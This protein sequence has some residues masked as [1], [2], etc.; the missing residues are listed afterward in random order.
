MANGDISGRGEAVRFVSTAQDQHPAW[1]KEISDDSYDVTVLST[2]P[3]RRRPLRLMLTADLGDH[4]L[5][6]QLR[7]VH[8]RDLSLT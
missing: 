3:D 6:L 5:L 4:R 1:Q 8:L 7:R 2:S